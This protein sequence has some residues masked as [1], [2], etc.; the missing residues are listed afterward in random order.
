MTPLIRKFQQIA[1]K[2]QLSKGTKKAKLAFA[3]LVRE[4]NNIRNLGRVTKGLKT[5]GR[6]K[7]GMLVAY[8]YDPKYKAELPFYDRFPLV[9]ILQV[10]KDGWVGINLHYLHPNVRADLFYQMEKNKV[11]FSENEMTKA[12]TKR[13]LARHAVTRLKEFP[14]EMWELAAQLPFENFKNS[15]KY[16]V[17]KD[18]NRKM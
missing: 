14:N 8:E 9:F 4:E 3:K 10:N 6:L 13:Y 11:Q 18:T 2:A 17:W 1:E 7:P 16:N 15:N 5:V 12:A